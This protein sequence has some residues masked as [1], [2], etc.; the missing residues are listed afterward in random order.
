MSLEVE[1]VWERFRFGEVRV[2]RPE[3]SVALVASVAAAA[4]A[5]AKS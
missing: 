2:P 4:R 5:F 1:A 3:A